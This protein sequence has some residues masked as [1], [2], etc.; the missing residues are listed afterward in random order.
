ML[1]C[2]FLP[3]D[4]HI[5]SWSRLDRVEHLLSPFHMCS[6][7]GSRQNQTRSFSTSD[8]I[9]FSASG[10]FTNAIQN[11]NSLQFNRGHR[12]GWSHSVDLGSNMSESLK[13]TW[14]VSAEDLGY[15]NRSTWKRSCHR[16]V[17][18]TPAIYI[19]MVLKNIYGISQHTLFL[20]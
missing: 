6:T 13:V 17:K 15:L 1:L 11:P 12:H 3:N 7:G 19:L 14:V 8:S 9:R 10:V 4:Q 18:S 5:I 2:A 16:H 20:F